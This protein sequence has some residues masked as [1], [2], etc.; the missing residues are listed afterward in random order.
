MIL[1]RSAAPVRPATQA[2]Y[3]ANGRFRGSFVYLLLC[4]S[5]E[6]IYVK[7]GLS[8]DPLK[9]LKGLLNG[10]PLKPGIMAVAELPNRV[11]ALQFERELHGAMR[12][13]R[14]AREWFLFSRNDKARFNE[15][16]RGAAIEFAS[17]SWPIRW[18]KLSVPELIRQAQNRK[19]A[20]VRARQRRMRKDDMRRELRTL[21]AE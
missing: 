21:A 8:D 5:P 11:K 12:N 3:R 18:D 1:N 13:F 15:L 4:E 2:A 6:G 19:S 20:W 17:P 14:H 9:R 7:I 10:C 16:L